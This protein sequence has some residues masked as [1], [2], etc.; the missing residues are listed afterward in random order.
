MAEEKPDN[1]STASS[2][3]RSVLQGIGAVAL[4]SSIAISG[5]ASAA[6]TKVHVITGSERSPITEA[7]MQDIR[8]SAASKAGVSE[9]RV[10]TEYSDLDDPIVGFTYAVDENGRSE[11][12]TTIAGDSESI[13][14]MRER[15]NQAASDISSSLKHGRTVGTSDV[16]TSGDVTTQAKSWDNIHSDTD[17]YKK[18]PYGEVGN[19]HDWYELSDDSYSNFTPMAIHQK[20]ITTPGASLWDNEWENFRAFCTH[21]WTLGDGDY[22]T[23]H[24]PTGTTDTS[25][26]SVDTTVNL[27]VDGKTLSYDDWVQDDVEIKDQTT[28]S[29][30]VAEWQN[31]Y[32]GN[33]R[34]G[35]GLFEPGS[36]VLIPDNDSG[37]SEKVVDLI[38]KQKYYGPSASFH[39]LK[40]TYG[41]VYNF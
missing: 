37:T 7:E 40:Y 24:G 3:R 11:Q 19:G 23:D 13:D 26:G 39:N 35:Y 28:K 10:T 2:T 20:H 25:S 16:T 4:G 1:S 36:A 21:D 27:T 30:G 38:S 29:T 41:L 6:N 31:T 34:D 15:A 12:T 33:S 18:S 14:D 8:N 5:S 17:Y 32:F 9:P 22:I